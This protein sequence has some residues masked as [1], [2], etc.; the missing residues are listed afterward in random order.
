MCSKH[1]SILRH[2]DLSQSTDR[3]HISQGT[4]RHGM[5]TTTTS[6]YVSLT[7][8][9]IRKRFQ[10][11]MDEEQH[12]FSLEEPEPRPTTISDRYN[13]YDRS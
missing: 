10:E 6:S 12:G 9:E 8:D 11:L 13:P 2:I 4:G 3:P 1:V 7:L 5:D